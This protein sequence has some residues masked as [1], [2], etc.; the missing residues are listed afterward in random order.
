M[1]VYPAHKETKHTSR[2]GLC[3]SSHRSWAAD[4]GHAAF[5][6]PRSSAVQRPPWR[7]SGKSRQS[8]ECLRLL[9]WKFYCCRIAVKPRR[10]R[11]EEHTSELQS[12][13]YLVCRLLL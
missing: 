4:L 11:S 12:R 6:E 9:G 13:Q 2:L 1:Y 5:R 10:T 8:S 3:W 7:G